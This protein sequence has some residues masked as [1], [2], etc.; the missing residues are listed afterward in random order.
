[1]GSTWR[2]CGECEPVCC[3]CEVLLS[4]YPVGAV[5]HLPALSSVW[6]AGGAASCCPRAVCNCGHL[7]ARSKGGLVSPMYVMK[8]PFP[9]AA[10][11]QRRYCHCIMH[12]HRVPVYE[13][14]V[15]GSGCWGSVTWGTVA[16]TESVNCLLVRRCQGTGAQAAHECQSCFAPAR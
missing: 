2:E 5:I 3:S 12:Y 6:P 8:G 7:P 16:C 4:H 10:R 14:I 1:M 11:L 15:N 9:V 13:L